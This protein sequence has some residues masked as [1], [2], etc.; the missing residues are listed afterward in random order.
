[1]KCEF[2]IITPK[3]SEDR[4]S[5]FITYPFVKVNNSSFFKVYYISIIIPHNQIKAKFP[6][7][8]GDLFKINKVTIFWNFDEGCQNVSEQLWKNWLSVNHS[9]L[10][11]ISQNWL[12]MVCKE[13]H[14]KV[15]RIFPLR[16]FFAKRKMNNVVYVYLLI[17]IVNFVGNLTL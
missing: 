8:K 13:L 17:S 2:S 5:F 15:E 7:K 1:M 14:N 11:S 9:F 12:N 4:L 3:I 16:D 10:L 6:L